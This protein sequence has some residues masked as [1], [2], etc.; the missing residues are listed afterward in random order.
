LHNTGHGTR[1]CTWHHYMA[2]AVRTGQE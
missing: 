2:V 1:A